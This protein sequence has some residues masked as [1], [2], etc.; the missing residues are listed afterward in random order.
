[1]KIL[2]FGDNIIDRFVDRGLVYP[3]G[4]CVNVAVF[5]R[6]LGA[7]AAY[8]GVFGSDRYGELIR[9]AL[10]AEGVDHRRSIVREGKSGVSTITV[11][12]GERIFEGWNGGGVTVAEPLVLD[13]ELGTYASGFDL[14]HSSVYS[15]SETELPALR[16]SE[17]LVSYDLS[18]EDDYRSAYYLDRVCPFID[19]ALVSGS[20]LDDLETRELL[21]NI[22]NR[23]AGLALATRG[24]LGAMVYDGNVFI[25]APAETVA[26]PTVIV[27]T[28]GCGDAFLA[29]FVAS[30][31]DSGW[32]R[33]AAPGPVALHNALTAGASFASR[34]CL[35]E[36]AFGHGQLDMV[37]P[38]SAPVRARLDTM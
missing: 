27:D 7:D 33:S 11:V 31:L 21:R 35:T 18:S 1:M 2:G 15:A 38:A 3:G 4:N 23:G 20:H 37:P 28:M 17:A 29:A 36:G 19:L 9:E 32:R 8:L 12:D 30:L 26:D 10:T 24:I 34:Q 5:A 16:T 25:E 22:V 13:E 14:I 6:M